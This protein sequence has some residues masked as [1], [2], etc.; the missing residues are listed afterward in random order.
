VHD[1]HRLPGVDHVVDGL[2]WHVATHG[3]ARPARD[4]PLLLLHGLAPACGVVWHDVAR[5]LEHDT[6]SVMPDLPGL[7]E[8]E[9]PT[10]PGR[11]PLA[12]EATARRLPGLLDALGHKRVVVVGHGIGGGVA[13]HFA[14]S[15]PDRV[16][17][18]VLVETPL[19][20]DSWPPAGLAPAL[21]PAVGGLAARLGGVP[22]EVRAV[23]RAADLASVAS[24]WRLLCTQP[25]PVLIL[26]GA[27][28]VSP[29]P[30]YGQALA[31]QARG[32]CVEIANAGDCLPWERPERVAEEIAAFAAELA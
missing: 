28:A 18:L 29:G 30:A 16:A 13:V 25:G 26:W 27:G 7:G 12:L 15:H 4:L 23:A 3:R 17:G 10:G 21:L 11:R 5:D 24:C 31:E 9:T 6:I 19:H 2:R 14:A 8:T 22:P 1:T 32:V 20:P